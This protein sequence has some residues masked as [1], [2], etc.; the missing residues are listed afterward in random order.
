MFEVVFFN[1]KDELKKESIT[2]VLLR[3][4]SIEV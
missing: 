3:H 4:K 1:G 2:A